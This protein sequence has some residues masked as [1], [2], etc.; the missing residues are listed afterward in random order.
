MRAPAPRRV[1][2]ISRPMPAAP[3]VT[4]T[5]RPSTRNCM[6]PLQSPFHSVGTAGRS[7]P[8]LVEAINIPRRDADARQRALLAIGPGAAAM[9]HGTLVPDQNIARLPGM[10]I[11]GAGPG[12]EG[13]QLFDEG[14]AL[15]RRQPVDGKGVRGD[16]KS[17][18]AADRIAPDSLP[19]LL[20]PFGELFLF[21]QF[22]R[23]P[24]A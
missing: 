8:N 3:A 2:T 24:G 21:R 16:V 10:G 7:R 17:V 19:C 23:Y 20:G 9:K 11:N 22:R 6:T 1:R 14:V 5:R 12:R 18:L 13:D 4:T 15:L